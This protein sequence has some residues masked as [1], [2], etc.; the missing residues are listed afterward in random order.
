MITKCQ[1]FKLLFL[2]IFF[3]HKCHTFITY[4][5]SKYP[6]LGE[7]APPGS[8]WPLPQQW[9]RSTYAYLLDP[10][11][12]FM[13]SNA[14][15]CT[16][17]TESL[18]RLSDEFNLLFKT[19][20]DNHNH[21]NN[22]DNNTTNSLTSLRSI[23]LKID[24]T[25]RCNEL[26]PQQNDNEFY[27]ISIP[28]QSTND[29]QI[30]AD[31]IWGA[32]RALETLSQLIYINPSRQLV[33]NAT[34]VSD[35]PRFGFRGVMLDSSRHFLPKNVILA[36]LDAMAYNKFN[37]FH[38]HIVDDQSFPFESKIFPE[39]TEKGAY[40]P[41]HV[42]KQTDIAEIIEYAR[43][44]GIRVIPEFDTPGH[45]QGFGKA[46]PHLLTPC[47]G[48]S[49]DRPFTAKYMKHATSEILNP[50]LNYTYDFMRVF[51]DEVKRVFRDEYVHLGMDEVYYDCWRSNPHIWQFMINNSFTELSQ[52]E[53][54]YTERMI[55]KIKDLGLKHIIWQDPIDNGVHISNDTLV[56]VWKESYR[57][58]TATSN[59]WKANVQR[60]VSQGYQVIV[61]ACWYLNYI[62]YGQD[63]EKYYRCD[64]TKSLADDKEKALVLGG[65]ACMWGE[66]VDGTNVLARLWPRA[67]AVA[68]RLWSD[69]LMTNDIES[70]KYRLD[71]HRC[72]MLRRGIP[73]QPILNGFCGDYEWEMNTNEL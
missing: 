12:F 11:L 8:P 4:I 5:E 25:Y 46:F 71:Q 66:Y 65:E 45:T 21:N 51:F 26:Y 54:Y 53:Q 19:I 55:D 32:I 1:I 63:W 33:I 23:N 60:I 17:V 41:K 27:E 57:H 14:D 13:T 58:P 68:E 52:V 38:W 16:I 73:A 30:R 10:K 6:L 67:S 56:M 15:N 40:S 7:D 34:R 31:T 24:T 29:G 35:W 70:A 3:N 22:N 39:L 62:S 18:S 69:P 9:T 43:Y 47:Y 44:R 2:I 61:S 49:D 59:S 48:D 64:P 20:D 28:Y 50:M 72:R 37:V 42:Y 36:N